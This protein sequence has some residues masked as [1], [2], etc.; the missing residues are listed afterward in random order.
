[1]RSTFSSSRIFNDHGGWYVIMRQSDKKNL[2]G[3]KYKCIG[4]Q[5]M[6]GPFISKHQVE[7]WLAGFLAMYS[8]NRSTLD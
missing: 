3:L 1:M 6:M 7:T 5:H 2:S 4:N 8:E